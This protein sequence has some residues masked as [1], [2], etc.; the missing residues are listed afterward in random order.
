MVLAVLG[1]VLPLLLTT[2]FELHHFIGG[3]DSLVAEK[4]G[5]SD[6]HP[7]ATKYGSRCI[8]GRKGLSLNKPK[9]KS[10]I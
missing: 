2:P 10:A 7:A 4:S 3:V 9:Y 6:S 1:V 5:T 8:T